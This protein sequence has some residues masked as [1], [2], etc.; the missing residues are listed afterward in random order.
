M[1][2]PSNYLTIALVFGVIC[3]LA[4]LLTILTTSVWDAPAPILN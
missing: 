1:S 3:V 4:F 2:R